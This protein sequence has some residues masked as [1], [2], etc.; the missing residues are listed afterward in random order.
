[1]KTKFTTLACLVAMSLGAQTNP[2][3]WVE[4][5]NSTNPVPVTLVDLGSTNVYEPFSLGFSTGLLICGFGWV[6]RLVRRVAGPD[7]S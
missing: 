5:V 3:Q 1:M 6:L 2:V 4:V 7:N